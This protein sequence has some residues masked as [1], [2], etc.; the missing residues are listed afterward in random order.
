MNWYVKTYFDRVI[1]TPEKLETDSWKIAYYQ[2][3]P[4]PNWENYDKRTMNIKGKSIV[5]GIVVYEFI[6]K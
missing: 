6:E 1:G 5:Y 4:C 3:L 2:M